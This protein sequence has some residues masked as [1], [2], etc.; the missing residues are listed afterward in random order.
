MLLL[1]LDMTAQIDPCDQNWDTILLDHFT[2][3]TW[4]T[5]SNWLIS[6]PVG[7]YKAY[8]PEWPSGVSRGSSEHQVYQRENCLFDSSD[9]LRLVSIYAGGDYYQPLQCGEYDIPPGKVCDTSHHTLF[10]TSGKIE[11]DVKYLYGYFEIRCS[12]PVHKGSFPAFWLY[13]Q[14]SNYYNELDVFEYSWGAS[15]NDHYKQFSCG[16]FCDNDNVSMTSYARTYPT[17]PS[18][19]KDLRHPHTFACEWLPDRITWYVDGLVVNEFTDYEHIPHHAM[20]IKINYAIDN[21]AV[22]YQTNQPVWFDGDKMVIEY[23]KILQLKT[24]CDTDVTIR[25]LQDLTQYQPSVKKAINIQ[26]T[27]ELVVPTNTNMNF[28]AVD[29]IAIDRNF[30]LSQGAQ[31]TLQTQLCPE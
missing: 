16:V 1:S 8:I 14:G 24:D 21:Y 6:N 22:P 31:M 2:N 27:D 26:P 28:R 17:L 29:S 5:W 12:L 13:G 25:N 11:T 3:N 18:T 20:A 10:Y 30:T 23:V 19:S 15:F 9:E 4:N 7:Y